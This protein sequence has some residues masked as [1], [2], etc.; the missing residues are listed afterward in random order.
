VSQ[1]GGA[2]TT[3][4]DRI[5]NVPWLFRVV[6]QILDPGQQRPVRD[7]L[8]Q[9]PHRSVL[10]LGCGLGTMSGITDRPYMGLDLVPQYVD[11]AQRHFGSP[12]KRFAVGNALDL[13]P[14]LGDFDV[15]ALLSFIHH[16]S[17]DE[18]DRILR[19]L[20]AV[21][22]A[23]VLVLD[24]APER[25]GWVFNRVLGPLDRGAH[26]RPQS[27]QRALLEAAG[28]RVELESGFR[29]TNRLNAHS[30]FLAAYPATSFVESDGS[31]GQGP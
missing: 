29:S 13:D 12:T 11:Y 7:F 27:A 30:L 9:V 26:L 22:P 28:C 6:R 25:A 2:Q 19:G 21:S 16:F 8:A 4:R 1:N 20:R 15:V 3:A 14:G 10:E 31:V 24:L 18:V 5:L 23:Y 17:D